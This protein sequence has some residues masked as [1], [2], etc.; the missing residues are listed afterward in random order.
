M[1]KKGCYIPL[2]TP[3]D[4]HQVFYAREAVASYVAAAVALRATSD[5]IAHL[6]E[7]L[8]KEKEAFLTKDKKEEAKLNE[9]FHMGLARLS[10]NQ[11]L[12]KCCRNLFWR[13]N[14]YIFYFDSFYRDKEMPQLTPAQHTEILDAIE[15]GD[16]ERAS[17]AMRKHIHR[18][19]EALIK[20]Q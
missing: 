2:P 3:E 18:T 15:S 17:R 10:G 13:S 20:M 9:A 16:P 11:Y 6:R 14:L 5:E 8:K 1:K 7:I 19:Y 4:A 12:Q